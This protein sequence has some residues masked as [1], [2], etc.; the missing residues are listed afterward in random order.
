[1][2][3]RL[4]SFLRLGGLAIWSLICLLFV[5]CSANNVSTAAYEQD[6][7]ATVEAIAAKLEMKDYSVIKKP[8]M[9]LHF[10]LKD[11]E[12][13]D[14]AYLV[15]DT[16][17]NADEIGIIQASSKESVSSIKDAVGEHISL[18][19]S[20][21]RS[22]SNTEYTK[23][24]SSVILEKNGYV[25]FAVCDQPDQAGKLFEQSIP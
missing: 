19:E 13:A 20:S 15:S 3:K 8:Q 4:A 11:S 6:A 22:Y 24:S 9:S 7:A 10:V 23:V 17:G 16:E 21:Y 12:V 18:K 14:F 5:S 25:F 2:R 1:M